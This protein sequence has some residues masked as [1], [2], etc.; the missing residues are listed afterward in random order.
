MQRPQLTYAALLLAAVVLGYLLA[1][2]T[3]SSTTSPSVSHAS[4]MAEVRELQGELLEA[5]RQ[6][7]NTAQVSGTPLSA[8]E[9]LTPAT[10]VEVDPLPEV[11]LQELIKQID[12]LR[13]ELETSIKR[14][15]R[16]SVNTETAM[17]HRAALSQAPRNE[18]AIF[19][20]IRKC[21][22]SDLADESQSDFNRAHMMAMDAALEQYG[23]PDVLHKNEHFTYWAYEGRKYVTE[24]EYDIIWILELTF[25]EGLTWTIEGEF[26]DN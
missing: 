20:M 1:N 22:A 18:Q 13:R 9:G 4:E 12:Q 25:K 7:A 26:S 16:E 11:E 24:E 19:E 21:V 17:F 3:D 15:E 5:V 2:L 23:R 14:F 6:L 8:D 10:R